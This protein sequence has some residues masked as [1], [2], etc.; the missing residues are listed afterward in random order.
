MGHHLNSYHLCVVL[1]QIL[2][3][4]TWHLK[5]CIVQTNLNHVRPE[6]L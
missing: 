1:S 5:S 2:F 6:L 3:F 4:S